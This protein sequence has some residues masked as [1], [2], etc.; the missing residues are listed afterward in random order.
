LAGC[1]LRLCLYGHLSSSEGLPGETDTPEHCIR[2]R[3]Y[4]GLGMFTRPANC[5]EG[6]VS[7]VWTWH[8]ASRPWTSMTGPCALDIGL[9][10]TALRY[11]FLISDRVLTAEDVGSTSTCQKRSTHQDLSDSLTEPTCETHTLSLYALFA[12]ANDPHRRVLAIGQDTR[13][14]IN[15]SLDVIHLHTP[16]RPILFL[17]RRILTL[18]LRYR[19]ARTWSGSDQTAVRARR[20]ACS[21]SRTGLSIRMHGTAARVQHPA[22]APL[23]HCAGVKTYRLHQASD[24]Y[25]LGV[26]M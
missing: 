18:V 22:R 20:D 17:P 25:A 10:C 16:G 4:C 13:L 12:A 1:A 24:V 15:C 7:F 2:F 14:Y 19:W 26:M 11:S 9:H 23:L 6:Y 8:G 21:R 5:S 3:S